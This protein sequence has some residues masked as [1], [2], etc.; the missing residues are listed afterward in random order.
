MVPGGSLFSGGSRRQCRAVPECGTVQLLPGQPPPSTAFVCSCLLDFTTGLYL[1]ATPFVHL[2]LW[3]GAINVYAITG[4]KIPFCSAQ[5][6][7]A[8][9]LWGFA[10]VLIAPLPLDMFILG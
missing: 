2:G 7:D 3:P 4:T 5:P 6:P 9:V 8:C 1:E 10:Y